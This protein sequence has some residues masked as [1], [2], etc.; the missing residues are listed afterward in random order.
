[1]R[2]AQRRRYG[3]GTNRRL[4]RRASTC[5]SFARGRTEPRRGRRHVRQSIGGPRAH[6][7]HLRTRR[8]PGLLPRTFRTRRPLPPPRRT[9]E[10]RASYQRA[11]TWRSKSQPAASFNDASTNSR[12][13]TTRPD[14]DAASARSAVTSQHYYRMPAVHCACVAQQA[15]ERLCSRFCASADFAHSPATCLRCYVDPVPNVGHGNPSIRLASASLAVVSCSLVPDFVRHRILPSLSRVTASVS[16]SAARSALLKYGAS[17]HA[18]TAKRRS[19]VSSA[20][21]QQSHIAI[22]THTLHH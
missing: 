7:H 21:L 18:A 6:R 14:K 11:S 20:Y 12:T 10:A 2:S 8:S 17:L 1:M 16:A 22:S 5:Q 15:A 13:S 19:F 4:V 3:L 9:A